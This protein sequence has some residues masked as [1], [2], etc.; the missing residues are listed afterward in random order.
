MSLRT[1]GLRRVVLLLTAVALACSTVGSV[2]P[3][4]AQGTAPSVVYLDAS[5]PAGT[6]V[7]V[8][9]ADGSSRRVVGEML[10]PDV[11]PLDLRGSLLAVGEG[12]DLVTMDLATG[13]TRRLTVG[14]RVQS[15]YVANNTT[16]F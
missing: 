8:A 15:A 5:K 4:H 7:W 12:D 1:V 14:E 10:G 2:A 6:M 11:R 3:V 16:V 9:A 13:V